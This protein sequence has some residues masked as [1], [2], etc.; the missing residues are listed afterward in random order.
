MLRWII[1]ASIQSRLMVA[2]VAVGLMVYGFVNLKEMPVDILPEFSQP[3]VEIQTEALGLSAAEVEALI[4][5]PLEADMLNGTP[6]LDEIRSQSIPGLSSIMLIF[7]TGTDLMRARQMVQERL[8]EVHTLPNVAKSPVMLNP[9]SSAGRVMMIGLSSENLSLI[10]TSVL[11]RWTIVPRLMGV[12]GVANVSIWG[13]RRRQLQVQV[14]PQK[15]REQNTKLQQVISTTGN[16]LWFSPLTYLNASTPGTAGFIDTPNQRLGVRHILP[17]TTPEQLADVSLEGSDKRLG[18]VA[19]VVE[20]HQPLIGDAIVNDEPSLLLVVEKLPG[21]N[22]GTVTRGVEQALDAMR[23]GL[24][25]LEMDSTLF[26]PAS[27]IEMAVAGLS[28]AFLISVALVIVALG[29]FLLDA[30]ALLVSSLSILTTFV[31]AV[32]VLYA[33]SVPFNAMILAGFVLAIA[34]VIDDAVIDIDHYMRRLRQHKRE[35]S[36]KSYARVILESALE[37]RGPACYALAILVLI[38]LPAFAVTGPTGDFLQS[39]ATGFCVAVVA[40]MLVALTVMPALAIM[41]LPGSPLAENQ[42]AIVGQLHRYYGN[43]TKRLIENPRPAI[44]AASLL[45]IAG[46]GMLLAMQRETLVPS[47]KER[48]L[49]VEI[50]TAP[51]TSHPE[52]NRVASQATR[53]LRSIPGVRAVSANVG[54]AVMSDQV[55]DVNSG[56]LWVSIDRDAD[57]D[58]TVERI[59]QVVEGYAGL[60]I[61]AGTYLR[62]CII[63]S[64]TAEDSSDIAVR[65]YGDDWKVLQAK[66]EEVQQALA[67]IKGVVDP[68]VELPIQE[69]QVEIEV[70][71][72]AAQKYGLKPGDVRRAAATLISG[73]EVGYLFENQK[74]FDV[75]VW[76]VPQSRDSLS[77]IQ[78]LMIDT[79]NGSYATL[80]EVADIRVVPSPTVIR[81]ESVA[82]F[83]EVDATAEGRSLAAIAIDIESKLKEIDFPLE[84]RAEL[85]GGSA[86][87][88]AAMRRTMIAIGAAAVGIFLV[89]QAFTGSW[90]LASILF[91]TLPA[92]IAGGALVAHAMGGDFSLGVL[93]GIIGV[94]AIAIRNGISLIG[95]FQRLAAHPETGMAVSVTRPHFDSGDRFGSSSNPD[96]GAA[97]DPRLV[98]QATSER[99]TPILMSSIITAAAMLPLVILGDVPGNEIL[100]PM[101]AVILGGLVTATFFT[102]IGVP[103]IMALV[104]PTGGPELEDLA[105]SLMGEE[106]LREAIAGAHA[107]AH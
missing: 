92:S 11:A 7:E 9:V 64:R 71:M 62:A 65:I 77:K 97:F 22:T 78:N 10:E 104:K 68:M 86:D 31:I 40:A 25:G 42:S 50:D 96:G 58:A 33:F 16:A 45:A 34:A 93:L 6:W 14:D 67:G 73:I 106:E 83:V 81:R 44:L 48:D 63:D 39:V 43:A 29:A 69:S 94:L 17:I 12:E 13:E 55:G 95:H 2:A 57:Y 37:V 4:T 18:D 36:S 87:R 20:N 54:R 61:D 47:F 82:R 80:K 19:T 46:V 51:G 8:T 88:L 52:M 23:P 59:N 70:K 15:L 26:R 91:L 74:V 27:Y 53:E 90:R 56:E 102:L 41:L 101:A 100:A 72:D 3:Y 5:V 21:A 75:V 28:S 98:E 49:L 1:G 99:F 76:G 60:D 85:R 103:A 24:A 32:V 107:A 84:Y 79:P 38:A 89:L 30:R 105:S 35:S 66:A